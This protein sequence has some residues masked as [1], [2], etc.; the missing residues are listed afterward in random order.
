MV[1]HPENRQPFLSFYKR[2]KRSPFPPEVKTPYSA[3][4]FS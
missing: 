3:K 1:E 4:P 2:K